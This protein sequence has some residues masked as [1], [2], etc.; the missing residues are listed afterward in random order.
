MKIRLRSTYAVGLTAGRSERDAPDSR[1]EIELASGTTVL[2]MLE[3]F[4]G[5]GPPDFYDDIM[6]HVFVNGSLRGFDHILEHGDVVDIHIP[7]S[8]G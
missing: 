3:S 7:V 1:D 2:E 6:I 4:P 8:G 5:L